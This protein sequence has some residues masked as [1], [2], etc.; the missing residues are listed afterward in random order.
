M[1]KMGGCRDWERWKHKNEEEF[2]KRKSRVTW[3]KEGDKN[4]KYFHAVTSERRKR[5]IIEM[6]QKE[7][8]LKCKGEEEIAK[9]IASYFENLFTSS[10]P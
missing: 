6:L 9:E 10:Q 1:Q 2:W 3:L 8:G 4:T 7:D 5:N